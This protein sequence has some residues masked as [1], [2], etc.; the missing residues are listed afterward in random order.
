MHAKT[1]NTMIGLHGLRTIA[2][3][4]LLLPTA[5]CGSSQNRDRVPVFPTKGSV[6]LEGTSPKGALIVLHPKRGKQASDGNAIRPYA[7]IHSDVTFELT[8]YDSNDGAPA[9]EYSVTVELRKVIKYPNG[10]AGPG[11]NL[12]PKKYTKPDTSPLLVQIQPGLNDLPP[13]VLK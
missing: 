11:P 4:A 5:G 3:V 9:G 7:T 12:V 6:K 1:A 13:L 8:S 10:G 2:L